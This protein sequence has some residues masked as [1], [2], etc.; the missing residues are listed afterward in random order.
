MA[1][2]KLD[3]DAATP[4]NAE[5]LAKLLE[6]EQP[7]LWEHW[8]Q[9]EAAGGKDDFDE[10]APKIRSFLFNSYDKSISY[11]VRIDLLPEMRVIACRA[12]GKTID[13]DALAL[14]KQKERSVTDKKIKFEGVTPE[15]AAQMARLLHKRNPALWD[16]WIEIERV[17]N[18]ENEFINDQIHI[19]ARW[20]LLQSLDAL[21]SN[22]LNNLAFEI[23]RIAHEL[24]IEKFNN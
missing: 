7:A 18:A 11:N 22:E 23:R 17:Y 20:F 21:P 24:A 10:I 13:N 9:S 6:T 14:W 2:N 4:D 19:E 12:A 1:T 5:R 3:I 15:F 16:C 8:V